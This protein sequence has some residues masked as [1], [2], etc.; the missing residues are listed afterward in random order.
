VVFDC[1]FARQRNLGRTAIE[2]FSRM[3]AFGMLIALSVFGMLIA[4]SVFGT[5]IADELPMAD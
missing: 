5:Q 1:T 4:L 2:P 3:S